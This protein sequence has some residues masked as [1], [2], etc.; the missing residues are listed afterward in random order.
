[1]P[2]ATSLIIFLL[3]V[4]VFF[5]LTIHGHNKTKKE[6]GYVSNTSLLFP[7]ILLTGMGA[8]IVC[9]MLGYSELS[10]VIFLVMFFVTSVVATVQPFIIY[11]RCTEVV[12][13]KYLGCEI[14]HSGKHHTANYYPI[15]EYYYQGETYRVEAAQSI[16][17]MQ[18]LELVEGSDVDIYVCHSKPNMC[19]YQRK[20]SFSGLIFLAVVLLFIFLKMR[21]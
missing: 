9:T 5:G 14:H 10:T 15:F 16:T 1:M 13:A 20:P 8:V 11:F 19:I 12:S 17:K 6:R 21:G 7:I 2:N 18:S 3:F 4:A